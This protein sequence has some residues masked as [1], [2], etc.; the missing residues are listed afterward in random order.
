MTW[1]REIRLTVNISSRQRPMSNLLRSL[2]LTSNQ[3]TSNICL[4][5]NQLGYH[6]FGLPWWPRLKLP[7]PVSIMWKQYNWDL[8]GTDI[9]LLYW[10]IGPLGLIPDRLARFGL[11]RSSI[12]TWVDSPWVSKICELLVTKWDRIR[13]KDR[14]IFEA[15]PKSH[16]S[17]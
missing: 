16:V 13:S 15:R 1:S 5:S 17:L 12:D 14:T 4:H 9:L 11:P 10:Y 8:S 6:M 2:V 3:P 7:S